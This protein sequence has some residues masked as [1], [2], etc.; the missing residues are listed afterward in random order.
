MFA[1]ERNFTHFLP[2]ISVYILIPTVYYVFIDQFV[3]HEEY[4]LIKLTALVTVSFFAVMTIICHL[5]AMFTNP[6]YVDPSK[7]KQD[8]THNNSDDINFLFKP[9]CKHCNH[10]RPERSHHCRTCNKCFLKMD[11]HCPWI[12]NC[13]GLYNQKY[14]ILFLFYATISCIIITICFAK[15][16]YKYEFKPN[17]KCKDGTHLYILLRVFS[18]LQYFANNQGIILF[19]QFFCNFRDMICAT[20]GG[21]I[22]FSLTIGIGFLLCRQF[23]LIIYNKTNVESMKLKF[24]EISP[25]SYNS[26]MKN[27]RTVMGKGSFL[28]FFLPTLEPNLYIEG[29][30]GYPKPNFNSLREMI[31]KEKKIDKNLQD[32]HDCNKLKSQ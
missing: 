16:I 23:Y 20:F 19:I 28:N 18:F 22:A 6:G 12:G 8:L 11:H 21:V 24:S 15:T 30:E 5:K 9:F 13:V 26:K 17:P 27:L 10:F 7:I 32:N 4:N 31:E 2:V 3:F 25:Y 29:Y 1:Q 14:F